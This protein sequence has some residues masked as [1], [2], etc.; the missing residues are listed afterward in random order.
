[1]LYFLGNEGLPPNFE[2]CFKEMVDLLRKI[3][4]WWIVGVEIP[5]NPEFDKQDIDVDSIVP[6]KIMALQLLYDI[7]LGSEGKSKYYY[8][9]MK[10]RHKKE[11]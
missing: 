1:M 8:D 5:C 6:G 2:Q 11:E 4:L 3:E 9:E 10:K 7:A